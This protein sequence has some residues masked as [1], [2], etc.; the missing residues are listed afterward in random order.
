MT[1]S[2]DLDIDVCLSCGSYFVWGKDQNKIAQKYG[3]GEAQKCHR[4]IRELYN[5]DVS[6]SSKLRQERKGS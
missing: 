6:S 5:A 2:D 3:I 1:T 4:C